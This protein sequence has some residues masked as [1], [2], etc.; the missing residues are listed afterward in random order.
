MKASN[1]SIHTNGIAYQL[2][3]FGLEAKVLHS[4]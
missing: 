2:F 4:E 3:H 1:W